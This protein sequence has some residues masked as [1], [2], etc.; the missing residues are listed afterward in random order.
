MPKKVACGPKHTQKLSCATARSGL[1]EGGS[2]DGAG[3]V[4]DET[5]VHGMFRP[6]QGRGTVHTMCYS[7]VTAA[8]DGGSSPQVYVRKQ[9]W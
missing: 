2:G 7:M 5:V 3:D 4:V 1:G 8:C 6:C 9:A